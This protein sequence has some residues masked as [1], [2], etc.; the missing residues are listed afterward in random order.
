MSSKSSNF[1]RDF[2]FNSCLSPEESTFES[3]SRREN[4]NVPLSKRTVFWDKRPKLGRNQMAE[5]A[6]TQV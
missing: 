5:K 6:S 4:I 3:G 2:N 1:D